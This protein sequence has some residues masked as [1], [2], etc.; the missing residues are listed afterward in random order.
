MS[1]NLEDQI[2]QCE[3]EFRDGVESLQD[4]QSGYGF[5]LQI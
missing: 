1:L 2:N 5:Y 3:I 4:Q